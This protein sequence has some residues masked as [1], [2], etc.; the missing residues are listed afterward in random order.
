MIVQT[1]NCQLDTQLTLQENNTN[2]L[3]LRTI[4]LSLTKQQ[5][6]L[7]ECRLA[8][9]VNP[10]LYQGIG[11]EAVFSLKPIIHRHLTF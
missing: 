9:S 5:N 8:F 11:T 7:I 3:S 2:P 10:A 4:N 1:E 6:Q